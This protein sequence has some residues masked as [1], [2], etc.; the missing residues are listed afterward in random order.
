ME[1][2]VANDAALTFRTGTLHTIVNPPTIADGTRTPSLGKLTFPLVMR[3]VDAFAE[4]SEAA[5][6][7]A[8]RFA[9]YRLK[10][11]VEPSGALGLAALRSGAWRPAHGSRVGVI[12]SGGNM[13]A[14]TMTAILNEA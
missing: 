5:I 7:E 14:P 11:V 4:V 2:E 3:H 1:P 9:F 12:L 13:D 6:M 10:L 8:V